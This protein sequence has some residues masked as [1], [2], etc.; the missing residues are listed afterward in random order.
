MLI[1]CSG[2]WLQVP[3]KGARGGHF[4]LQDP[5]PSLP[6]IRQDPGR[7]PRAAGSVYRAA[8]H[9]SLPHILSDPGNHLDRALRA[10]GSTQGLSSLELQPS[11]GWFSDDRPL[12]AGPRSQEGTGVSP[13]LAQSLSKGTSFRS[14]LST[15]IHPCW[16]SLG[17]REIIPWVEHPQLTESPGCSCLCEGQAVFADKRLAVHI[18]WGRGSIL[19]GA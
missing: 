3:E 9:Q 2:A 4:C 10:Y 16:L 1:S 6:R 7:C 15:S 17:S 12:D 5:S 19:S 8:H 18:C 14:S 11:A 13:F